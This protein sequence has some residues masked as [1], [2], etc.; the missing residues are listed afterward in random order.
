LRDYL[1]SLERPELNYD[2][3]QRDFRMLFDD[4]ETGV[5]ALRERLNHFDRQTLVALISSS[6]QDMSEADAS[7]LIDRLEST[8]DNLL[9]QSERIQQET[10]RRI[11]AV[12]QQ[13]HRQAIATQK[14]AAGAAWWLFGTG[15]VSLVASA[16]AGMLA[17]NRL[18]VF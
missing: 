1:N 17:V 4:P 5:E 10:Q 8:R 2:G 15:A 7:R 12:R 3:I 11:K 16:I 13:A 18:D 9:S 14:M 6:R